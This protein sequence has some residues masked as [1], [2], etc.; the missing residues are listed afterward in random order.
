MIQAGRDLPHKEVHQNT[1]N[2]PVMIEL[3]G[4]S[5][6]EHYQGSIDAI[7]KKIGYNKE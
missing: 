5:S 7:A 2:E 1:E 6:G 4:L 3:E